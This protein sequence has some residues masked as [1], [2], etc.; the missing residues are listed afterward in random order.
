MK[1]IG[2]AGGSGSGKSSVSYAL[3]DEKPDLF[4]VINLDD[5]QKPRDDPHLPMVEGMVNWDHPDIIRW[6]DLLA[7]L[8]QLKSGN[9]V[10][11][12]VWAHRSN[13][14]YFKTYKTIPRTLEPKSIILVEGYLALYNREL[15]ALY[16]KMYY[17][18]LD[19]ETRN[20]RRDKGAVLSKDEY[21]KKVLEPMHDQFVEP[22]KQNADSVIDVSNMTIEEVKLQLLEDLQV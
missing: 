7:D 10:T 2:I 3:V 9:S 22:T 1:I 21:L 17:F 19:K 5:Y 18:E 13:P 12:E 4:E 15:N 6:N 20:W 14:D 11:I 16:D 8:K